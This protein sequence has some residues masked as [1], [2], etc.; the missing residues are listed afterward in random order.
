MKSASFFCSASRAFRSTSI[1]SISFWRMDI[2][3]ASADIGIAVGS[4]FSLIDSLS[5]SRS[6]SS[7]LLPERAA[8]G[9]VT[10]RSVPPDAA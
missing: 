9:N 3:S 10:Y 5:P 8:E 1:F 4:I 7:H 6:N 2:R